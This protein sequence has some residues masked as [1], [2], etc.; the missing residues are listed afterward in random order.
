MGGTEP[1]ILIIDD[2]IYYAQRA[3]SLLSDHGKYSVQEAHSVDAAFDLIKG[4]CFNLI[5]LDISMPPG[6]RF[7]YVETAGG[8]KTGVAVAREVRNLLP[9]VKLIINTVSD[10]HNL[11]VWYS[12]DPDVSFLRKTADLM[13]L[14]RTVHAMLHSSVKALR[15]F[16]VHGHD[17]ATLFE[18]KLFLQNTLGLPQPM[19]LSELASLGRTVIEKFEHYAAQADVVFVLLT[20]DD[21]GQLAGPVDDKRWRARQNVIFELGYFFGAARRQ[22]GRIFLLLKG[23]VEIPSDLAG[24]IYIR[25]DQG[26][27]A[28]GEQLRRELNALLS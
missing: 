3:A 8:H 26:I 24:V 14:L 15:S 2:D 9:G 1:Q 22:S 18:L 17:R 16:I 13:P 6:T 4:T 28:A 27:E 12:G 10:D 19:V 11:E 7:D 20:G 5:I 21:I 25:I 23:D